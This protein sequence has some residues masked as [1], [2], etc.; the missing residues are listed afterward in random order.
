MEVFLSGFGFQQTLL[1]SLE[2]F[3]LSRLLSEGQAELKSAIE[4]LF[5]TIKM[6]PAKLTPS[7]LCAGAI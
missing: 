5:L 7:S 2:G 6:N 4:L 3:F 1:S